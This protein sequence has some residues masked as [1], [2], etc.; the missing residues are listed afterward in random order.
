MEVGV[1]NSVAAVGSSHRRTATAWF[2]GNPG[3]GTASYDSG[4]ILVLHL[5]LFTDRPDCFHALIAC[6]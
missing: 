1:A 2:S 5:D 4:G 3:C 6:L